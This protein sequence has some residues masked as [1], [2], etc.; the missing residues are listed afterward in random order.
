[1]P[2]LIPLDPEPLGEGIISRLEE[3][4]ELAREGR[5]S[6]IAIALVYRDGAAGHRWSELPNRVT[7][8]GSISR[9]AHKINR[10]AD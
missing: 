7:M 4:L 1:M 8:L 10:Q 2:R 3:C 9:L 5:L 6:S